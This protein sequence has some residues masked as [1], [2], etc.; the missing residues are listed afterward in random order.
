MAERDYVLGANVTE[1]FR[2]KQ[3]KDTMVLSVRLGKQE[4]KSLE[5]LAEMEHKTVSQ[6][7]REAIAREIKARTGGSQG[8][9]V[10]Y[11]SVEVSFGSPT[12]PRTTADQ[13]E[14]EWDAEI[15]Q[16]RQDHD[17]ILVQ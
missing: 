16:R 7:A 10:L 3:P 13:A 1:T 5:R 9:T 11:D 8:F 14:K 4:F 6:V 17:F 2:S 15:Q 12:S